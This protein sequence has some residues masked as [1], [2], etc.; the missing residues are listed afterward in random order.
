V[1][2]AALDIIAGTWLIVYAVPSI[3]DE[4]TAGLVDIGIV[5]LALGHVAA[6]LR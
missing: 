4:K 3:F 2:S 1:F 5:V 6:R